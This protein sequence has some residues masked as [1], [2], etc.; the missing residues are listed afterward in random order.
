[1]GLPAQWMFVKHLLGA[2]LDQRLRTQVSNAR[3]V[4]K[5]LLVEG[6]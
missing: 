6:R 2:R 4:L 5:K 3:Q 1:M